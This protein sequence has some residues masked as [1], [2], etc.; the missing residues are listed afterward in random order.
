M[1][2]DIDLSRAKGDGDAPLSLR[3]LRGRDIGQRFQSTSS[4]EDRVARRTEEP[5]QSHKHTLSLNGT[6]PQWRKE[7]DQLRFH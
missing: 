2:R 6:T 7:N 5:Q 1:L 3:R 4:M